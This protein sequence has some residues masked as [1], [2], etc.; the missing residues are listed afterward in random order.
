[1]TDYNEDGGPIGLSSP[2]RRVVIG[3]SSSEFRPAE[4]ERPA[5]HR[6]DRTAM[7]PGGKQQQDRKSVV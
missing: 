7:P 5:E 4:R 3:V 2:S 6:A 1:M